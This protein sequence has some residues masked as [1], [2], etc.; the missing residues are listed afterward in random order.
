MVVIGCRNLRPMRAKDNY[1]K[2]VMSPE[3]RSERGA[4]G[5]AGAGEAASAA[6]IAEFAARVAAAAG[7]IKHLSDLPAAKASNRVRGARAAVSVAA[8]KR[9]AAPS[10]ISLA[11]GLPSS[12]ASAGVGAARGA[13]AALATGTSHKP[14][15][16]ASRN[17]KVAR[18]VAQLLGAAPRLGSTGNVRPRSNGTWFMR[19]AP[20]AAVGAATGGAVKGA[21][22][23]SGTPMV[24]VSV[25]TEL[26]R[27]VALRP[28]LLRPAGSQ[29]AG[30][31]DSR[32]AADDSTTTARPAKR[33]R[34][35]DGTAV[36]CTG[37]GG[38]REREVIDLT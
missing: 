37:D 4:C 28:Q 1:A 17:R 15:A 5:A 25:F 12:A 8:A 32:K 26:A 36:P 31:K 7:I 21:T 9:L 2:Q 14:A 13:A 34:L 35:T 19:R 3:E 11:G 38:Q 22:G 16:T 30:G 18:S 29:S 27:A 24:P 33:I 10:G 6:E 23:T 20:S